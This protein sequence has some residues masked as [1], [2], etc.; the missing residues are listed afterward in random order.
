MSWRLFVAAEIPAAPRHALAGA[1]AG[2]RG[3]VPGAR[4]VAEEAWHVTLCFLGATDPE[5]VDA[6]AGV[7]REAAAAGRPVALRLAGLG[8][9][10]NERR[11]RV[12]WV[13]LE[14]AEPL[15]AVAAA[16]ADGSARLGFPRED[17]PWRPHLTI[18]RLR[19]PGP[20]DLGPGLGIGVGL[21]T[22]EFGV[23][24]IVLFRSHLNR[25]GAVYEGLGR[26]PLGPPGL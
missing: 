16:L 25:S 20:V 7:A 2:L 26:F 22:E 17:R 5:R 6:V 11:A 8:A 9:F 14:G 18:A 24:E 23:T 12:V 1:V 10:P 19:V 13:G 21:R 15:G 4:W 3:S